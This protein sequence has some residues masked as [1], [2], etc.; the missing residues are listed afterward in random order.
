MAMHIVSGMVSYH[1]YIRDEGLSF[2][3]CWQGR[4]RAAVQNRF[5][6]MERHRVVY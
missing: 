3:S 5:A 1:A 6:K 2:R 4:G